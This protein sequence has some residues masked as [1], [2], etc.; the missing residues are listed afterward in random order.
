[1]QSAFFTSLALVASI[2]LLVQPTALAVEHTGV[3]LSGDTQHYTGL[4]DRDGFQEID[5]ILGGA[6]KHGQSLPFL[7]IQVG[8]EISISNDDV[9]KKP[10]NSK[11]F[12]TRGKVQLVQYLAANAGAV[13]QNKAFNDSLIEKQFSSKQ[14]D[15]TVIVHFADTMS[16][17]K[18]I[19]VNRIA[20]NKVKHET[21][22]FVIDDNGV[23]LQRWGMKNKSSAIIVL[24]ASGKVLFAKDGPL[25]EYEIES[26][27]ALIENQMS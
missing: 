26:T 3:E 22:H 6:L 16:L 11:S 7:D 13:R 23:G 25:S 20:K 12:E 10:W 24:D 9:V 27:I 17:L 19:V 1:M 4:D 15:T 5:G 8:G 21:I 18:G 2:A 14:L